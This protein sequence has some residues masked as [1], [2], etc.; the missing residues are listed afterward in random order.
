MFTVVFF[1][2]LL[3]S[4][5]HPYDVVWLKSFVFF[6]NLLM[7][8]N[9]KLLHLYGLWKLLLF[10]NKSFGK[11]D[12]FCFASRHQYTGFLY[13]F[14][15]VS[16][17][18]LLLI[19]TVCFT[20]TSGCFTSIHR[21]VNTFLFKSAVCEHQIFKRYELLCSARV[22]CRF[23]LLTWEMFSH[24]QR[25]NSLSLFLLFVCVK[26]AQSLECIHNYSQYLKLAFNSS[27]LF[28]CL[29]ELC[30]IIL[31]KLVYWF[32][33]LQMSSICTVGGF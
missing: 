6:S 19:E 5:Q 24:A 18:H 12:V 7:F 8:G 16:C 28:L 20:E 17:A 9:V 10:V 11:K 32:T 22:R 27:L 3:V 14:Q 21:R 23:A 2:F 1:F 15:W 13:M 29:L 33:W 30:T 4:V 31:I 25:H 26:S